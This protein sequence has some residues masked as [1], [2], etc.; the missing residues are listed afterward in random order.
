MEFPK[1][2]TGTV[3][4]EIGQV[5][6]PSSLGYLLIEA[7]CTSPAGHAALKIIVDNNEERAEHHRFEFSIASEVAAINKLGMLLSNW[8]MQINSQIVWKAETR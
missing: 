8:Q 5:G 7:Y 6:Y 4:F 3:S 2:A 1:S